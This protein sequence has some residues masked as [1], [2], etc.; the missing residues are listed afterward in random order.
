MADLDFKKMIAAKVAANMG[1]E[2]QEVEDRLEALA[3]KPS[4]ELPPLDDATK[5]LI[6]DIAGTVGGWRAWGVDE[7]TDGGP[8]LLRSVTHSNY[9]WAPREVQTAVCRK[10]H[11]SPDESCTCGNYS[12]KTYE[13]LMSM[14]YHQYDADNWG[15]YSAVGEVANW[16]KVVEGSQGWRAQHSYPRVIY[17]PFEAWHIALA[18]QEAYGVPV[19]LKNFLGLELSQPDGPITKGDE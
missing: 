6:P 9:V 14:S 16:G 5:M 13:H 7:A 15:Y 10:G 3:Q 19:K 11:V 2:A 18:L 17:V 1:Q 8:P 4:L 12:A